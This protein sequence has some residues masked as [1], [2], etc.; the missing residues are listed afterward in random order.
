MIASKYGDMV[1]CNTEAMFTKTKRREG[2][3]RGTSSQSTFYFVLRPVL[4]AA[5]LPTF[6]PGGAF[7]LT[8]LG[9]P[10]D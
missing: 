1:V 7:L 8:V 10:G 3:R 5:M 6:L 2:V 4:L 9:L